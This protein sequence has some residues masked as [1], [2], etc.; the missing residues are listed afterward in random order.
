M[1]LPAAARG[2]LKVDTGRTVSA[3]QLAQAQGQLV[4]M[5]KGGHRHAPND[6]KRQAQRRGAEKG[7]GKGKSKVKVH[8][9]VVHVRSSSADGNS[10][11]DAAHSPTA[12][13]RRNAQVRHGIHHDQGLP[14]P[15]RALQDS[16]KHAGQEPRPQPRRAVGAAQYV[17]A[18]SDDDDTDSDA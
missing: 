7:K 10:T 17:T 1:S 3:T 9:R 5:S 4:G 13:V 18:V 15:A 14:E 6:T 12:E 16:R 8:K 11:A 2:G